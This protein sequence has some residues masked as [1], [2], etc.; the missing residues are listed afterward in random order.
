MSVY[1]K[2]GTWESLGKVKVDGVLLITLPI[3]CIL[4]YRNMSANSPPYT[5]RLGNSPLLYLLE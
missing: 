4:I 1:P 3:E 2:L 5:D